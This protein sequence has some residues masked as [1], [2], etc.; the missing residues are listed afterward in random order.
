[1]GLTGY[2]RQF[3][4]GYGTIAKPLTKLLK[5]GAFQWSSVAKQAFH[6]LKN[7]LI[8]AIV[9]ALPDFEVE[10]IVESNDSHTGIG[11]V[12]TQ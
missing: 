11:V 9:L 5:N 7:A 1:M 3:I 2:Y 6:K 10:F 12:L 4:Q 8:T